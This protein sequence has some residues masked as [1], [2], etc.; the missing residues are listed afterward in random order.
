[1]SFKRGF[2]NRPDAFGKDESK[3]KGTAKDGAAATDV[4]EPARAPKGISR[5]IYEMPRNF[6]T[7]LA[8]GP[9]APLQR[10]RGPMDDPVK[11]YLKDS[12]DIK[13]DLFQVRRL[14]HHVLLNLDLGPNAKNG[15][16]GREKIPTWI[17]ADQIDLL[18]N[19]IG[20]APPCGVEEADRVGKMWGCIEP[21][22]DLGGPRRD[23]EGVL[24]EMKEIPGKGKGLFSLRDFTVGDLII[25]ERPIQIM[26]VASLNLTPISQFSNFIPLKERR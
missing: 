22:P 10:F 16:S 23:G 11:E 5:R 19:L 3:R 4:K 2:L 14:G 7:I 18:N 15:E 9:D 21:G 12:P 13:L 26:P 6:S 17:Y 25:S 24:W 20:P 1:M 8:K